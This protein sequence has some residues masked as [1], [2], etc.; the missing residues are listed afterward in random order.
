MRL[1]ERA[2]AALSRLAA[3][4]ASLATLACLALV[5]ISVVARYFAGA[6]QPWIDKVAGWLVVALVLLAAPEAQRRFEHIG[7]DIAVGRI[8]PR[9]ARFAHLLGAVAVAVVAGILLAAGIEAVA[10]SR[11][12][13]MMTDV[14]GIP[15]WWIQALLPAGAAVLLLVSLCQALLLA[16]GRE[17]EHLPRGDEDILAHDTL[18]RGE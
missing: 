2:A 18:A 13:G 4:L 10:F 1:I 12:V 11:M 5:G 7:V 6:P 3:A 14:E 16:L 8:G 9:I 17:P 15:E